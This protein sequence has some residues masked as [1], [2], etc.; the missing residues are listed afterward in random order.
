MGGCEQYRIRIP[1][2]QIRAKVPNTALDWA[3]VGKVQKWAGIKDKSKP[4]PSDYDLWL[5]PRHRPLPYGIDGTID[6][7][8]VPE[9]LKVAAKK[10]FDIELE[11]DAHLLDMLRI[12]RNKIGIVM[13]YDDDHWGSRDLG[14]MEYVDLAQK[15]LQLADAITVTTP[16]M[17]QLVKTYAPQVPVYILPNVVKFSEWQGWERWLRWPE[18]WLVIGLT[19]SPTHHDDWVVLKDVI[20]R[21]L[22]EY[23]NVAFLL[24]GYVPDFFEDLHLLYPAQVYNDSYFRTYQDYPGLIRQ[25]DIIL[26][27]VDPTD[28]F[29][30]AKSGI[31]AVEGMAAGRVLPNGMMGGAVPIVS[32]LDYYQEAVGN[33]KRGLVVE[34]TPESWERAI[35]LLLTNGTLRQQLQYRGL[36]YVREHLSIE[37]RWGLWWNAYQEIYRRKQQ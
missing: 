33:D 28:K 22:D 9:S 4:L 32:P 15:Q 12:V 5:L 21:I 7:E 6:F 25:A 13:E 36:K 8:R 34:H 37:T 29:N 11:G 18:G 14:Y 2:E 20:P 3:P 10:H 1:F 30:W 17:E 24:A 27:P 35:R 26:C 31:K 23:H 16:Y 19:G